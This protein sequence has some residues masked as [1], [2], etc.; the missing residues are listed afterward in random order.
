MPKTDINYSKTVIYVI[1]HKENKELLYV[2][3]TTNMTNRTCTHKKR[4][5]SNPMKLYVMI[6]ENGGW[7]NFDMRPIKQISCSNS[8][9]ARI[10]E[11]KC[12][13]EYQATMNTHRAIRCDDNA[14]EVA[15]QTKENKKQWQIDNKDKVKENKKKYYLEN[16]ETFKTKAKQHHEANKD[17][18]NSKRR[19]KYEVNKE[20]VLLKQKDYY[21]KIKEKRHEQNKIKFTCACGVES[22]LCNKTRHEK[23]VFH[24]NYINSL[25]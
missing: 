18:I 1:Q 4:S 12:R 11:E 22:D 16:Q 14:E 6:R 9:E 5:E 15:L 7:D 21:E 2:G 8:I 23:S 10:E 25:V 3:H 24:Q 13:C 19:E 20:S 17:A